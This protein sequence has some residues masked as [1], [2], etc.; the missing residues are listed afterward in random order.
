MAKLLHLFASA[1]FVARAF[2]APKHI[3][4]IVADDLGRTDLGARNGG[5]TISPSIDALIAEGISL[6]SYHTFKICSP[7]RASTLTGRYP[8]NAGFYDMNSDNDHTTTNFTLYPA[9]LKEA[10]YATHAWGKW[11]VGYF[12]RNAT[13]TY[14]GFDTFF[15]YY[16]A[17]TAD[18]WFYSAASG[19]APCVPPGTF[20]YSVQDWADNAGTALSPGDRVGRNGTYNR[21]LLT[22]RATSVIA[23]HN[24][25]QPLYYYLAWHDIHE[26][27]ARPDALGL[28]APLATVELYNTTVQDAYKVH[29]A[30]VTELDKGVGAVVA[31]LKARGMWQDTLVL[32]TS[33]NGGPLNHATN[34]PLRGGKHTFYDG[35]LRVEA[36]LS[37]GAL[38]ANLAGTSWD[39]L[40]HASDIYLT[41]TEGYAGVAV[42]PAKTGGPAPLDGFNLWP[43]ILSGGASPRTEIIHQVNNSFFDEGASALRVGDMKLIRGIIG[44]NRTLA[45]PPPGDAPVPLGRTGAV[46]EP[47]TDHVRAP[48]LASENGRPCR[49]FCLFNISADM[50]EEHDLAHQP[51]YAALAKALIARLDEVGAA[52]PPPAYIWTNVSQFYREVKAACPAELAAGALLPID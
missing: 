15:G 8:F 50:G 4:V 37:G 48:A 46:V 1:L 13:A 38:P 32:F 2:A 14:R 51:R 29:G 43:A 34:F 41:L 52:A 20:N 25:T 5:R 49:P 16:A 19:G 44:D 35:G 42:D 7:S 47:G 3:V 22:A 36:F 26:A 24:P 17:C 40:A 21:E 23:A 39:G 9:L 27:C 33:D 30:M 12:V 18:Y 28:Q 45:F 10:G 31:A 6:T 11:D